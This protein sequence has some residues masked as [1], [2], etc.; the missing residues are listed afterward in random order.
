MKDLNIYDLSGEKLFT[1]TKHECKEYIRHNKINRY[2]MKETFREKVA[3]FVAEPKN[4]NHLAKEATKE[5][6]FN[7]VFNMPAEDM[8]D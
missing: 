4:T 7:R 6:Y 3:Q 1:G 5:G 2:K 8:F